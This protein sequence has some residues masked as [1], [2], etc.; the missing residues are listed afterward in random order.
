MD[1]IALIIY[2]MRN[3]SFFLRPKMAKNAKTCIVRH[4]GHNFAIFKVSRITFLFELVLTFCLKSST[5]FGAFTLFLCAKHFYSFFCGFWWI[6]AYFFRHFLSIKHFRLFWKLR[7]CV[8]EFNN[9]VKNRLYSGSLPSGT[10]KKRWVLRCF[11]DFS[12]FLNFF[13]SLGLKIFLLKLRIFI[14]F[15]LFLGEILTFFA[16]F[17]PH[18]MRVFFNFHGAKIEIFCNFL[19]KNYSTALFLGALKNA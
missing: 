13:S 11:D 19:R 17:Y 1:T 16:G 15:G 12:S 2:V 7:L 3:D 9:F 8:A 18:Y 6:F 10:Q 4:L 5:A 14:N